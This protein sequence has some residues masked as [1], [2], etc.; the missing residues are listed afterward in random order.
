MIKP[1]NKQKEKFMA[2]SGKSVY[3]LGPEAMKANSD[4]WKKLI[5]I[6]K[7]VVG[8]NES[9]IIDWGKRGIPQNVIDKYF[10]TMPRTYDELNEV[11][12][13]AT[14][15]GI[16]LTDVVGASYN[17]QYDS[18][19]FLTPFVDA[20]LCVS[21]DEKSDTLYGGQ[22]RLMDDESIQRCGGK[23]KWI[24]TTAPK[25][26]Q[27]VGVRYGLSSGA[28]MSSYGDIDTADVVIVTEGTLKSQLA[29]YNLKAANPDAKIA[30]IGCPGVFAGVMLN[31]HFDLK[32]KT[33]L[34]AFDEDATANYY[35]TKDYDKDAKEYTGVGNEQV[36]VYTEL[37][38]KTAIEGGAKAAARLRWKTFDDEVD[39]ETKG[40]DDVLTY[41]A[42]NGIGEFSIK[43]GNF[44]IQSACYSVDDFEKFSTDAWGK[45]GQ[46]SSAKL[47]EFMRPVR[48]DEY[49][50]KLTSELE[51]VL[52][53]DLQK[54]EEPLNAKDTE[55][56]AD[57]VKAYKQRNPEA[58]IVSDARKASIVDEYN[59]KLKNKGL[60][61][62]SDESI[63]ATT[64][65]IYVADA[66]YSDLS[67]T[68][69][70]TVHADTLK[71]ST[72]E[73]D[74]PLDMDT[75][76]DIYLQGG[77]GALKGLTA[78]TDKFKKS[79]DG[80]VQK[81]VVEG[82]KLFPRVQVE[83]NADRTMVESCH[84]TLAPF[85]TNTMVQPLGS[86][87]YGLNAG[88]KISCAVGLLATNTKG[89]PTRLTVKQK[90]CVYLGNTF[91][92]AKGEEVK[93]GR[94]KWAIDAT[95]IPETDKYVLNSTLPK[96]EVGKET[97]VK[98]LSDVITGK[99]DRQ[100]FKDAGIHY[101]KDG[102]YTEAGGVDH[103]TLIVDDETAFGNAGKASGHDAPTAAL[104][105]NADAEAATVAEG[106]QA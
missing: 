64:E 79:P 33:V 29:Y 38:L 57:F 24:S 96:D 88:D 101:V 67:L 81:A 58:T 91:T 15:E 85:N 46:T 99:I 76:T 56:S 106:V 37:L 45:K 77:A 18:V 89:V 104:D 6:I 70:K 97:A 23:Y 13:R 9:H 8:I 78:S 92:N 65:K 84:M 53:F 32:G 44:F 54:I 61:K 90:D 69:Y 48:N 102:R 68:P 98:L 35:Y 20:Y 4:A 50:A 42:Q 60:S 86:K 5:P 74:S 83:L 105:L 14:A 40:I 51:N 59:Y 73:S 52:T 26:N 28:T 41:N 3:D 94:P 63:K 71:C 80:K 12:K 49:D 93:G 1:T 100:T 21:R 17:P 7:D 87:S 66:H 95:Q 55:A 36:G 16:D 103:L 30:M 82:T 2:A 47:G 34:A 39:H 31:D 72:I 27:Q 62:G 43:N 11:M 75:L 19:N 25:K 10:V 22:I